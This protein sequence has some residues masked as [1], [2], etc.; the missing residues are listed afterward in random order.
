MQTN[1]YGKKE[2]FSSF[3][4]QNHIFLEGKVPYTLNPGG[5]NHE[6]L[7]CL[8]GISEYF[9]NIYK[10]HF[11][12]KKITKLA[13]IKKINNLISEYEQKIANR[14]LNFIK[15]NNNIRLIGKSEIIN[16]DRAPTISFTVKGMSSRKVSESLVKSGIA[17]RNDNFYAWRCLI[18]LGINA[19]DGVVRVSMVHYNKLE[20]VEKLINALKKIL[21]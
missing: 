17:L 18:A 19:D 13:K 9:E 15:K 4:D 12:E 21:S 2:I 10:H 5:P 6:E 14:L 11:N 8:I 7:S 20:E 16:K 1:I 3:L